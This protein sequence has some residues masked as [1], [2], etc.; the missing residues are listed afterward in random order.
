[1]STAPSFRNYYN[2]KKD[3][4]RIRKEKLK[5]YFSRSLGQH[6]SAWM[7]HR[8]LEKRSRVLRT[9]LSLGPYLGN[10]RL[11]VGSRI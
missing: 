9:S 5:A 10:N 6:L 2:L 7:K 1:M 8:D 4:R 3:S 11:F